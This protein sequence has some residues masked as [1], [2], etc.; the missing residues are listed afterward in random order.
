MTPVV[1][2]QRLLDDLDC[3]SGALYRTLQSANPIENLN[4]FVAGYT[5]NVERWRHGSMIIR[6]V[7][8][9]VL[10]AQ[11]HSIGRGLSSNL[12]HGHNT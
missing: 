5:R 11:K 12:M 1:G 6:W 8:A 9:A 4:G 2:R 10:E 7:S 3:V